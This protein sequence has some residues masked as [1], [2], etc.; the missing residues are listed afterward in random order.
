MI[1]EE[2]KYPYDDYYLYKVYH[3]NENRNYAVLIPKDKTSGL[4]RHTIAFARYLVATNLKRFLT[5]DEEV[6]HIDNDKSNDIIENLQILSREENISK[7]ATYHGKKYVEL[8]CPICKKLFELPKGQSYLQKHSKYNCCSVECNSKIKSIT[9]SG[10]NISLLLKLIEG[11][12][13]REFVKHSDHISYDW[14]NATL[15]TKEDILDNS[16]FSVFK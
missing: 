2:A 9:N 7:Y 8:R 4:K 1:R 12:F 14:N 3:K 13:V 16:E 11:N 15:F 10:S 5:K 6:D